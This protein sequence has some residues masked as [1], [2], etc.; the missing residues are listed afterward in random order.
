MATAKL[1]TRLPYDGQGFRIPD[2]ARY[3]RLRERGA[4]LFWRR[5][6]WVLRGPA[7]A[8]TRLAS[9]VAVFWRVQAFVSATGLDHRAA[10]RLLGDCLAS[11][12]RPDE[13]FIWREVFAGRHPLPRRSAA[14]VLASLGASRAHFRL[15]DREATAALLDHGGLATPLTHAIVR[16]GGIVDLSRVPSRRLF[17]VPRH[18]GGGR[19]GFAIDSS[20]AARAAALARDDDFLVQEHLRAD[21]RL[22]DLA[23]DGAA[24]VLQLTMARNPGSAPYLHAASLAIPVP[25]EPPR[26]FSRGHLRVPIDPASGVLKEGLWF[27]EPG[28]RFTR[29]K[30][31]SAPLAGRRMPAFAE[32]VAAVR[33][34]MELVPG[35]ALVTW[36]VIVTARGPVILEGNTGG[37]WILTSL[38]ADPGPLLDLLERWS[39]VES[40]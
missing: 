16:R 2:D 40:A 38:G 20:D 36:D 10:R 1:W 3:A 30:W 23:A 24:P 22:S 4:A 19:G 6:P 37:D 26:D 18:R 34:A 5:V 13:A 33:R 15:A 9:I 29:A 28:R 39:D 17:V 21:T 31:N 35:V 8:L 32:A 27:A 25:G 7:I 14:L 12:A 11:G